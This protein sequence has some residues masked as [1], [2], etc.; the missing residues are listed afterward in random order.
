MT[1]KPRK[2]LA[3]MAGE[4]AKIEGG[5][6]GIACRECGCRD[7]RVETTRRQDGLILR[8]RKCRNCGAHRA[9]IET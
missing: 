4:T 2:T 5:S 6:R 8:Y 9:T 7:L 3:E 1:E